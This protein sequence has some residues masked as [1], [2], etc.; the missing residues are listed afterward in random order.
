MDLL[1][2]VFG[3]ALGDVGAALF[4]TLV[5]VSFALSTAWHPPESSCTR[6]STTFQGC[7]PARP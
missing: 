7:H 5:G 1:Y 4:T 2:A 6:L 3:Y